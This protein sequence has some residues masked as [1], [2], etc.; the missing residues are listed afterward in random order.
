M[1]HPCP[2][3]KARRTPQKGALAVFLNRGMIGTALLLL[4]AAL[5]LWPLCVAVPIFARESWHL[6]QLR[7]RGVK[8]DIVRIYRAEGRSHASNHF[9]SAISYEYAPARALVD[10]IS[11]HDPQAL[12][13]DDLR[14]FIEMSR[15]RLRGELPRGWNGGESILFEGTAK[16]IRGQPTLQFVTFL[17]ENPKISAIGPITHT[18]IWLTWIGAP[19]AT[20]PGLILLAVLCWP[21]AR[22]LC[23]SRR[24]H[25]RGSDPGMRIT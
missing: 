19:K 18:R 10:P 6:W 4:V 3:N 2:D 21:L 13:L 25:W 8:A 24:C 14:A 11:L 23:Q 7:E 20:F 12:A 1:P 9:L 15:A 5:M 16:D 22:R 17:P